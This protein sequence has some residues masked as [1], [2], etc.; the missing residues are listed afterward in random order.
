M[1]AL[2]DT[3]DTTVFSLIYANKT[4]DDILCRDLLDDAAKRSKGRFKITYTL[5]FPPANWK[6]KTG[7]ITAAMIKECLPK[8][9]PETLIY[10]CGPPPMIEFACKKTLRS[11]GSPRSKWWFLRSGGGCAMMSHLHSLPACAILV[12]AV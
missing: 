1:G 11:S 2:A 10:M 3:S 7:F 4:E 9:G 5:D 12:A 8:P 6:Q